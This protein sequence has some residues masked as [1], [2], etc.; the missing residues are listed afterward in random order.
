MGSPL[1]QVPLV[2]FFLWFNDRLAALRF[3]T[4]EEQVW[5][6]RKNRK[7]NEK[8]NE[9]SV[10]EGAGCFGSPY[11]VCFLTWTAASKT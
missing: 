11:G 1:S 9:N 8:H 2:L 7:N 3:S 10:K 6:V 5:G 4:S